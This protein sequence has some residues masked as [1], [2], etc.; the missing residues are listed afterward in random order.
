MKESIKIHYAQGNSI[1]R[2]R[3]CFS[4]PMT[5]RVVAENSGISER[6]LRGIVKGSTIKEITVNKLL[7]GLKSTDKT[8]LNTTNE[9]QTFDK[10]LFILINEKQTLS[11]KTIH[12]HHTLISSILTTAVQWQVIFSN[13]AERVKPP[14]VEQKEAKY[15]DD[16]QA[17]NVIVLLSQEEIKYRTAI[18]LLI[19][20]GLR[21]G[22]LCGLEWAD[23]DF[24]NKV[25][26]VRRS[27]QFIPQKGIF[28]K[29]PKNKSSE[30][31]IK[32]SDV[33]FRLLSEYKIW[34][35]TKRLKCGDLWFD[36]DRLFTQ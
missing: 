27:S 19:Y 16:V 32:L 1:T 25:L 35:N 7:T 4:H 21:R 2:F 26:H 5:I 10:K 3:Q 30:R 31:S 18:T 36:S 14:K 28:D 34:K 15:L 12:H 33:I 13:P 9:K 17:Q 24:K 11:S 8:I 6:T 29:S 22:E 20:S 23:V